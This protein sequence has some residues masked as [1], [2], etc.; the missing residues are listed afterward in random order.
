LRIFG[1]LFRLGGASPKISICEPRPRR[2]TRRMASTVPIHVEFGIIWTPV[3]WSQFF[4]IRGFFGSLAVSQ[5]LFT[6]L[7]RCR[8]LKSEWFSQIRTK[9]LCQLVKFFSVHK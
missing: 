1:S 8:T 5:I 7:Q 4:L 6:L 9:I 2:I 3:T